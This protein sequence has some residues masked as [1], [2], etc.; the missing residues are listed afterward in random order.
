[1]GKALKGTQT[2]IPFRTAACL[3]LKLLKLQAKV[4][5]NSHVA[6]KTVK[7]RLNQILRT[8]NFIQ[9][10]NLGLDPLLALFPSA[11]NH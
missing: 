6:S 2:E 3:E 5:P 11:F 7:G 4:E 1:M 8:S 9:Q 10:K